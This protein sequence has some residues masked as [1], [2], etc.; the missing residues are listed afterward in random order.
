MRYLIDDNQLPEEEAD[1][2]T[3][4][5]LSNLDQNRDGV[6]SLEEF[7]DQYVEIIKKLRY[8]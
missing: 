5:I 3:Q 6:I 2:L 8:R 1:Q 7:S 4:E